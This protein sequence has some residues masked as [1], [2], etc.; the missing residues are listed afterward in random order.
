MRMADIEHVKNMLSRTH[1]RS[2][3]SYD[4]FPSEV[5]RHCVFVGTTNGEKYLR[6]QTGNRRFWPVVVN[7]IDDEALVRDRDQLWAEAAAAEAN[8]ESIRLD[9]SL[10]GEASKEQEQRLEDEP[11]KEMI[12]E[13]LGDMEGK[14]RK[15]D[16]REII[17]RPDGQF[18]AIDA[19]RF[20]FAMR[21]LGW[22]DE[23]RLRFGGDPEHCW[24]R[25]DGNHRT[26]EITIDLG[27]GRRC[28]KASHVG[29][30]EKEA[31]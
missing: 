24:Y 19:K 5:P 10:W 20:N 2:R 26:I 9:K 6:D 3:L 16:A 17:G 13:V 22:M 29:K 12:E 8:G 1:D 21:S 27:S 14:I 28:V 7:Q 31:M 15:R 25:G 11:W 18:T 30:Q 23:R 4:R